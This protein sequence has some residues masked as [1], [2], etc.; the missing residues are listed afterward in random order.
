MDETVIFI[1][2]ENNLIYGGYT[3]CQWKNEEYL[4]YQKDEKGTSFLFKFD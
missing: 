2:T 3:P 1:L 4:S